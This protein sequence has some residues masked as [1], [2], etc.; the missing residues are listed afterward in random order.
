MGRAGRCAGGGTNCID[1][2]GGSY[3]RGGTP[4]AEAGADVLDAGVFAPGFVA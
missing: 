2:E 4:R 3:L 1:E